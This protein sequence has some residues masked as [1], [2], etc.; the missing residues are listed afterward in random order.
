MEATGRAGTAEGL[1]RSFATGS[2]PDGIHGRYR[3]RP[4][5]V[6]LHRRVDPVAEA[7]FRWWMP[8]LGKRFDPARAEGWNVLTTGGCRAARLTFPRYRVAHRNRHHGCEAFRFRTST[9]P[10]ALDPRLT[11]LRIDYRPVEENPSWPVRRLLDELVTLDDGSHLGQALVEYGGG[12]HR[13]GWFSLER[14]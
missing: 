12:L 3:G 5:A 7:A 11:V 13:G 10:S 14:P 4:L 9:G 2:S 6:T 1:A 8:W